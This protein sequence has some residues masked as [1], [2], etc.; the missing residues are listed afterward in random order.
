LSKPPRN[1]CK[2]KL[3]ELAELQVREGERESEREIDRERERERE[4]ERAVAADITGQH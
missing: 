3:A 4:R 2:G 1:F